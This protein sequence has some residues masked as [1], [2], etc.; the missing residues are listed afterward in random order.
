MMYLIGLF[1]VFGAK[2]SFKEATSSTSD[3]Q[4]LIYV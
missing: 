1:R 3:D 2:V 4:I